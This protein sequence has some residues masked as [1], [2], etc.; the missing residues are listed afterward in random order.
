MA[1]KLKDAQDATLEG[2]CEEDEASQKRPFPKREPVAKF[3]SKFY[4]SLKKKGILREDEAHWAGYASNYQEPEP[5]EDGLG[6]MDY[7]SIPYDN[8]DQFN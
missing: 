5:D 1:S 4:M 2:R 3:S 7:N 6:D 8:N